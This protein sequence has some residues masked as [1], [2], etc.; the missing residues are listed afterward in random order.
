MFVEEEIR[1]GRLV[2]LFADDADDAPV[3]YHLVR[4]PGRMREPLARFVE[5]IR[6][7][8]RADAGA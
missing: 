8:A 4:R 6:R 1:A 5:W 2:V 3:G 7:V